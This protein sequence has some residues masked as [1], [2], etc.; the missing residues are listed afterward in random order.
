MALPGSS[1][2]V[3]RVLVYTYSSASSCGTYRS[4]VVYPEDNAYRQHHS[5]KAD[6]APEGYWKQLGEPQDSTPNYDCN[7]RI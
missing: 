3:G 2:A 5:E 7:E 1:Y 4:L 6:E